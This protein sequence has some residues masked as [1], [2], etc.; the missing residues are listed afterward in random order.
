MKL[1][2]DQLEAIHHEGTNLQLIACAG[3]G[4]TEVVARRIAALLDPGRRSP[5]EP[6]NIVAFTFTEKA[7]GELKQRIIERTGD[8]HGALIGM[9][10]MFVGTIHAFCLELLTTE[11]PEYMKYEVLNEVQQGLFVTRNSARCGLTTTLDLKGKPLHRYHD[12]AH[13]TTAL[14]IL[15]EDTINEAHVGLTLSAGLLAYQDLL[16]HHHYLDF[17][18]ILDRA[19][20]ALEGSTDLRA[21]L[22]ARIKHVVV[23][24]YQDVNP[25]QERL[26]LALAR[27]GAQI[28]VVGD[29]DQTI[30]QWRGSTVSNILSFPERYAPAHQVRLQENFRSSPG[31]IDVARGIIEENAVRIEKEMVPTGA[32][33]DENGDIVALGFE[34]PNQEAL[35]IAETLR[36]L[37]GVA[38]TQPDGTQRGMAW[39]DMAILFR[40]VANNAEPVTAALKAADIPHVVEGM[41]NL[42]RTDEAEAARQLF[43]FMDDR[44]G[45]AELIRFWTG[46]RFRLGE[47]AVRKAVERALE[48]KKSLHEAADQDRWSLYNLQRLFLAFLEDLGLTEDAT[49]DGEVI[50]YN[51]GKFSQLIADFETIYFHSEPKRKYQEFADFLQYRADGAYPE[52]WQESPSVNI[53]AVRIMTVH[54]AKGMQWPVVFLPALLRNRFPSPGMGGRNVWHLLDEE[55]VEDHSRYRGSIEDERR[56]FYVAIT[57]S[58][59]FLFLTHAPIQGQNN[60][61]ARPSVFWNN[62]RRARFVKQSRVSYAKRMRLPPTPMNSVANVNLTFSKLKYFFECPYQF[63]LRIQ[64]GFNAPVHEAQGYGKSLHDCLAE[65]HG[66]ALHGDVAHASEVKELV[67]RHLHLPFA[68]PALRETLS[69]S[70]RDVVSHYLQDNQGLLGNVEFSEQNISLDLG[71]CIT[72]SGRIDMVRRADTDEITIVDLKSKDRAQAEDLTETQLHIYALGYRELTGRDA[73]FVETYN[74]EERE[75]RSRRVDDDLIKDV[76][77]AVRDAARALRENRFPPRPL[78]RT[79]RRCDLRGLCGPGQLLIG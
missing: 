57:R 66:R 23:D 14:Q 34:D 18:S 64:Y 4:K 32:Q 54:K 27:A 30:Y 3:S 29:D 49:S 59:K 51:L 56:L 1:T 43:F 41:N 53:D 70:A 13:Y 15:R 77:A 44:I 60:R 67:A 5:F 38:V 19:A 63:K 6:A 2:S 8:A 39:S 16:S 25:I 72:V 76:T 78:M 26:I 21:R 10:R 33:A 45:A 58:Q 42:F 28:C 48:A 55:A 52:G 61:Y 73:D 62:A 40:S 69:S 74:L 31:V 37:H 9:A 47:D 35:F 36:E 17:S 24:E 22:G 71:G 12:S 11:V 46:P 75:E 79:C 7:A 20:T 65:V 68:Y 50:L